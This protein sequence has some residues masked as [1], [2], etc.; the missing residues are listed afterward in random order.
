MASMGSQ[1]GCL[2]TLA[3]FPGEPGLETCM[4][5]MAHSNWL[6]GEG[7]EAGPRV[8]P[9]GLDMFICS[10]GNLSLGLDAVDSTGNK[11]TDETD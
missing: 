7:A 4:D 6:L 10:L 1:L 9:W 5:L 3:T 11:E 2:F 8:G